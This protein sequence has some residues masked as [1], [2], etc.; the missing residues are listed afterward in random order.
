MEKVTWMSVCLLLMGSTGM[1]QND[2]PNSD[3]KDW[4]FNSYAN[5]EEPLQ[6]VSSNTINSV[7]GNAIMNVEKTDGLA[8]GDFAVRLS[9][10]VR[11]NSETSTDTAIAFLMSFN[12]ESS[13]FPV[14][15]KPD[16]LI[17]YYKHRG[18][19]TSLISLVFRNNAGD[20]VGNF[21]YGFFGD[22]KT[23]KRFAFP[24]PLEMDVDSCSVLI[25]SSSVQHITDNSS[26]I[27]GK[28]AFKQED[29]ASARNAIRYRLHAT[30]QALTIH[31]SLKDA[32]DE[33]KVIVKNEEGKVVK[34][35]EE[36]SRVAGAHELSLDV[37]DYSPGSYTY[38]LQIDGYSIDEPFVVAKKVK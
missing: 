24:I 7:M 29:R 11:K 1:A 2:L 20:S 27:I 4:E 25:V 6:Y 16:S 18:P 36:G 10:I 5:Y 22:Q 30:K 31:Y 35:Y 12:G 28:L 9:T 34:K 38:T 37:Q 26:F 33:V 13:F 23:F 19:D 21:M 32:A 17:G 8:P 3:F 14:F 15:N